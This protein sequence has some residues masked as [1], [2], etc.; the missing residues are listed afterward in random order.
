M[1]CPEEADKRSR[2]AAGQNNQAG[3]LT[4]PLVYS[5]SQAIS[6]V[7]KK[8]P[9][10]PNTMNADTLS[11]R[12]R[13][14]LIKGGE[15]LSGVLP[16]RS[17]CHPLSTRTGPETHPRMTPL[18][19][20]SSSPQ[21]PC[22]FARSQW[23]CLSREGDGASS[24]EAGRACSSVAVTISPRWLLGIHKNATALTLCPTD[25]LL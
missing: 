15:N 25:C 10:S 23:G 12:D 3:A 18:S 4:F 14:L 11:K 6:L 19:T 5:Q 1:T 9:S 16:T 21:L 24:P 8:G 7:R 13:A 2:R 17:Q 20:R 22:A